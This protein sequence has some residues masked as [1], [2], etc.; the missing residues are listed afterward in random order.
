MLMNNFCVL[1][2]ICIDC[3]VEIWPVVFLWF[4]TLMTN[5]TAGLHM[6]YNYSWMMI[7]FCVCLV[8]LVSEP[9]YSIKLL[10]NYLMLCV[11]GT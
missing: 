1:G 4:I 5:M 3:V 10:S 6:A 7:A 8:L 9:L 11:T 2:N